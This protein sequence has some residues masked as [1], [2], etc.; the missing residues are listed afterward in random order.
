MNIED[1]LKKYIVNRFMHKEDSGLLGDNEPLFVKGIIDS[2]GI[3]ELVSFIEAQF[4][5]KVQNDELVPENF[6]TVN[7][8]KD[9]VERKKVS[10]P[11]V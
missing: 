11:D 9:F 2:M 6:K 8:I 10:C 3:I 1:P 4:N 5:L 7:S